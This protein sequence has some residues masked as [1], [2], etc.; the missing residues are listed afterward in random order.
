MAIPTGVVVTAVASQI[1]WKDVIAAAPEVWKAAKELFAFS[2][3]K[4]GTAPVNP[5][6]DIRDQLA[7]LASRVHDGEQ[8]QADQAKLLAAIAGQMQ[9]MTT[10]MQASAARARNLL[11]V[12][13]GSCAVSLASLAV[14]LLN[15]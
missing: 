14:V 13:V 5:A 10:Q 8:A 3:K 12:A 4:A 15:Q 1:P 6:A 7:A 2:T 11:W 9:A